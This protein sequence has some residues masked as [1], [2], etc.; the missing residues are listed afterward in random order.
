MNNISR[1]YAS[2]RDATQIPNEE[3]RISSLIIENQDMQVRYYSPK[4]KDIQTP[5]RQNEVYV[6]AKGSGTFVRE[7]E[8]ISFNTGDVIFV[9]K[10]EHH[11]FKDFT[12][13]FATW[14]IF[15]GS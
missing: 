14:V 10:N 2:I 12:D 11:Y 7:N 5:H 15:Y 3:G 1:W 6:V 13:D 9:T 4:K 8:E